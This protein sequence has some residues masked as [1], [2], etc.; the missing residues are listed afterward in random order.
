PVSPLREAVRERL[1]EAH[2]RVFFLVRKP[3]SSNELGV[4]VV[5]GLGRGPARGALAG[6]I[7][8]AAPQDVARVVEVHDRLKALKI[9]IVSVG[10]DEVLIRPL[11]H[12][13][14]SW[15][16]KSPHVLS[17]QWAPARINCRRLAEQVALGKKTADAGV[18]IS[19][20]GGVSGIASSI[21]SLLGIVRK[22]QICGRADI[23]RGKIC[24]QRITGVR[25]MF[26]L[27]SIQMVQ[28]SGV[29]WFAG[30]LQS[31][32]SLLGR[33]CLKWKACSKCRLGGGASSSR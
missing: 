22:H 32:C 30:V 23:A 27:K 12:I 9:T 17:C 16:P 8:A 2:Q 26:S 10:F 15:Y 3:E 4:H 31:L 18:D 11:I 5:G 28:G 20:S 19:R 7:G 6:V 33:T 21:G 24:E 14:Q 1:H 25:E 13:A 29:H